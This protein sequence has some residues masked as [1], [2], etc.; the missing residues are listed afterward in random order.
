MSQKRPRRKGAQNALVSSS[1]FVGYVLD[2]EPVDD[3]MRKFE[4]LERYEKELVLQSSGVA[5]AAPLHVPSCND[6]TSMSCRTSAQLSVQQLEE[7]FSRTSRFNVRDAVTFGGALLPDGESWLNETTSEH[8]PGRVGNLKPAFEVPSSDESSY[9]ES[10]GAGRRGSKLKSKQLKSRRIATDVRSDAYNSNTLSGY[11]RKRQ[12]VD[13]RGD[14]P[15]SEHFG[16]NRGS[17]AENFAPDPFE[18]LAVHD[19]SSESESGGEDIDAKER[20]RAPTGQSRALMYSLSREADRGYLISRYEAVQ[21]ATTERNGIFLEADD[22]IWSG[23]PKISSLGKD[24][25]SS[26]WSFLFYSRIPAAPVPL[27][28]AHRIQPYSDESIAAIPCA[29]AIRGSCFRSMDWTILGSSYHCVLADPPLNTPGN[30][31]AD[32]QISVLELSSLPIPSLL[33]PGGFLLIWT[34]KRHVSAVLDLS[35]GTWG[36]RYVENIVWVKRTVGNKD[37]RHSM[38]SQRITADSLSSGTEI[39]LVLRKDGDLDI[40]H[41][42]NPDVIV[43]FV[44]PVEIGDTRPAKPSRIYDIVETMLPSAAFHPDTQR[45]ANFLLELWARP[46]ALR[47]GW[48]NVF[49]G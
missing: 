9:S 47:S 39:C 35:E 4:E 34:P 8:H 31:E 24:H 32:H 44:K 48:T 26:K 11:R 33:V 20:R 13:R 43:D 27:T 38:L 7:V 17:E 18:D 37:V 19:S 22:A 25:K 6:E 3:I 2:D 14:A 40:R 29:R 1:H 45:S 5:N 46:G 36:L 12:R 23:P 42:R 21:K 10:S 30:H 49:F 41:Q 15:P 16:G 28:W